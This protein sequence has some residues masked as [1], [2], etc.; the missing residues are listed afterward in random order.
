[1]VR[2]GAVV[3]V[4]LRKIGPA[5]P[6]IHRPALADRVSQGKCPLKRD[7]RDDGVSFDFIGEISGIDQI[8]GRSRREPPRVPVYGGNYDHRQRPARGFQQLDQFRDVLRRVDLP[9]V[10][11]NGPSLREE[12]AAEQ[13]LDQ[14]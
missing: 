6:V 14:R 9:Q 5:G 1:M 3:E 7:L 13:R 10:R 12:A 8:A 4:D 11:R 2:R